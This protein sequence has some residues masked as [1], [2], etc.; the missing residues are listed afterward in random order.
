MEIIKEINK[1]KIC[2][3][4][5]IVLLFSCQNKESKGSSVK[6]NSLPKTPKTVESLKDNFEFVE[7][8]DG[9]D[10]NLLY[11]KKEG[12]GYDFITGDIDYRNLFRGDICEIQ[13]KKDTVYLAGDDETAQI[14]NQLVSIKKIQDGNLSKFIKTYNKELKYHWNGDDG[15]SD[16][17][18][19]KLYLVAQYYISNSKSES[20]KS[21]VK[22]KEEIEYSIE[23][24]TMKN[25]VYE[26]LGIGYS[27]ENHFTLMQWVYFDVENHKIYEY[28]LPNDKLIEFK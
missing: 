1:Y 16:D 9:G 21:R 24:Q 5:I 18:L 14:I 13:W 25:R 17:Y 19:N 11:T 7:Y 23:E 12:K 28:D 4:I 26:V 6:E 8:N 15:Y 10:N 22:Q 3:I 20:I 27:F 2:Y